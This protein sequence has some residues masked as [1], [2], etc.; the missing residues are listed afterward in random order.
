MQLCVFPYNGND[1]EIGDEDVIYV[2]DNDVW[3]L[4]DDS[5]NEYIV[6][7]SPVS[8]DSVAE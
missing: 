7:H 5:Y 2:R 1:Q 3:R 8:A 6:Q 4:Q